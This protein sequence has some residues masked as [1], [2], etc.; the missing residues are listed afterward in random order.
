MPIWETNLTE[1]FMHAFVSYMCIIW[2]PNNRFDCGK[3]HE[4]SNIIT[5]PLGAGYQHI[6]P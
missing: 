2:Q 3:G 1:W 5:N 6:E 4:Y